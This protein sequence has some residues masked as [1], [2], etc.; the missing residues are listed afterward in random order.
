M[1]S[2]GYRPTDNELIDMIN[3]V[4]AEGT[5]DIKRNLGITVSKRVTLSE[6]QF[7]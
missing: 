4:D 6:F 5:Q 7:L 3:E 1:R 2:M